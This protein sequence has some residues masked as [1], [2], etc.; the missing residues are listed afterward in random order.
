MRGEAG[1]MRPARRREPAWT[2]YG[3]QGCNCCQEAA[4]FLFLLMDHRR[5]TLRMIDLSGPAEAPT[6]IHRLP[7]LM[8]QTGHVIWQGA[9][10]SG[11]TER[12]WQQG[13]SEELMA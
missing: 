12:A 7:A 8:D 3:R 11:A 6:A 5:V 2:F 10:D 13:T 4:R 9:F 1:A